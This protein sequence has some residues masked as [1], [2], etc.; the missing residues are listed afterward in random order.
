[1]QN[2]EYKTISWIGTKIS[3]DGNEVVD[4]K[5]AVPLPYMQQLGEQGWEMVSAV[6]ESV[7]VCVGGNAWSSEKW[8]GLRWY[9]KRLKS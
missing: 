5:N 9:F 8:G 4:N 7:S 3:I 6:S 2:W 1:M